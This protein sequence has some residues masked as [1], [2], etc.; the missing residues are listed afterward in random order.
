[1]EAIHLPQEPGESSKPHTQY[2]NLSGI[3]GATLLT[4]A[5]CFPQSLPLKVSVILWGFPATAKVLREQSDEGVGGWGGQA[6]TTTSSRVQSLH[7]PQLQHEDHMVPNN[8]CL[9][10]LILEIRTKT[11]HPRL[12]LGPGTLL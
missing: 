1:M 7:L 9:K 2:N 10:S 8:P 5:T 3:L 6:L 4:L 11:N 12:P